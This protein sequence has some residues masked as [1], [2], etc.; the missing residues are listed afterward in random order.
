MADQQKLFTLTQKAPDNNRW[1]TSL[2][3]DITLAFDKVTEKLTLINNQILK[4][5]EGLMLSLETVKKEVLDNVKN[6]KIIADSA[7]ELAEKNSED[8]HTLQKQ[9]SKLQRDNGV[10]KEENKSL[11]QKCEK[12]ELYS[13][14]DNL[15]IHGVADNPNETNEQCISAAKGFMKNQLGI[16]QN[17]INDIKFVRCHRMGRSGMMRPRPIIMRFC[18]YEKRE[19]VWQACPNLRGKH[20][21]SMSEDFPQDMASRRR[22]LYIIYRAA[23]NS[24]E[25]TIVKLKQDE[26]TLNANRYTVNNIHTLPKKINPLTLSFKSNDEAYVVGGL[27]SEFNPLSNW[28]KCDLSFKGHDYTTLEQGWQHQKALVADDQISAYNIMCAAEAKTA[29][30]LG[31]QVNLSNANRRKWDAGRK[32]LMLAMVKAKVNQNSNVKEALVATGSRKI[33][34]SGTH[35]P[36][37]TIGMRLTDANVLDTKLW[38]KDHLM[39]SVYG[40]IRGEL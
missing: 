4:D 8:I 15:V 23:K 34:E 1:G 29:K 18:D 38:R 40:Q 25:Y 22:L 36:F 39:G 13:R 37:Y 20:P 5:N 3:S 26:L 14:R 19:L 16:S 28:S 33:G 24:G 17:V 30:E 6:V 35:D 2:I 12:I 27:F 9:M 32:E 7:Q 10:L 31:K 21:Y 11:K